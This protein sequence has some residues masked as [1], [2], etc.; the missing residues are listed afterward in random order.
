MT[1]TVHAVYARGVLRLSGT[2]PLPENSR[3]RVTIQTDAAFPPDADAERAE[4]LK[5]GEQTLRKAW[6]NPD[7]EVFNELLAR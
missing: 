1:T 5:R 7:D 2:L 6:D 3:V 4:W